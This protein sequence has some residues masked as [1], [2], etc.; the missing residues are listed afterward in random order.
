MTMTM[1]MMRVE[2]GDDQIP[3]KVERIRV[4]LSRMMIIIIII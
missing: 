2:G 3:E 4:K 1:M